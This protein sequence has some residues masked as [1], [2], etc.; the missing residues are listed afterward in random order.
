MKG[1]PLV[2]ILEHQSQIPI[3]IAGPTRAWATGNAVWSKDEDW[4]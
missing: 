1:E 3:T 4:H 2:L